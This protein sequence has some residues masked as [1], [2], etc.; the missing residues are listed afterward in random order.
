[1]KSNE[2]EE[3]YKDFINYYNQSLNISAKEKKQAS[4]R[5]KKDGYFGTE[6]S[7]EDFNYNEEEAIVF[8]NPKSG[9]EIY[10]DI[11]NAFPDKNNPFFTHESDEDIMHLFISPD[12]STELVYYFIKAFKDKLEFF[13]KDPNKAFLND[14]DFLLRF[15]KNN[16][17][18]TK[19]NMT[20]TGK[21]NKL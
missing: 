3:F 7:F 20:L 1:M 17:Y 6:D 2:V 4:Q 11:I 13:K 14:I 5:I 21:K 16:S 18:A 12:Y 10:F 19:S 15:W 9:M 8:F